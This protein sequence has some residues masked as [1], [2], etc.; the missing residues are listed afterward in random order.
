MRMNITDV[1]PERGN[2]CYVKNRD[3]R[4]CKARRDIND[5]NNELKTPLPETDTDRNSYVAPSRRCGMWTMNPAHK[6]LHN[7]GNIG[8]RRDRPNAIIERGVLN[9]DSK[10][11]INSSGGAYN[12]V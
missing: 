5:K 2:R 7:P 3:K 9:V 4:C 12:L 1:S 8:S 10:H 11:A 6:D